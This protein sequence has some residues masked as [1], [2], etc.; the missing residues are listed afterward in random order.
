[1][2][3][4]KIIIRVIVLVLIVVAVVGWILPR[5]V[6]VYRETTIDAPA[7][8]VFDYLND[9]SKLDQ[10]SPWYQIDPEGT[11]YTAEGPTTGIGSKVSWES[12]HPDVGSG[13]QEIIEAVRPEFIKIQMYF[14][15]FDEP[16]YATYLITESSG[17]S[18]VKW[19]FQ[20]DFGIN[21]FYRC[22]GLFMDSMLGPTYEEG[23][24]RLKNV[25]E[26]Q[27]SPPI[28]SDLESMENDSTQTSSDTTQVM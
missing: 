9:L 13:S 8:Q 11:T 24:A 4:L 7:N 27:P 5:E 17:V 2:K 26:S 12:E 25:L 16:N 28:K 10:W 22:M 19:G 18:S 1:M 6:E 14:A 21:P 20:G 3:I 23:L 15:G